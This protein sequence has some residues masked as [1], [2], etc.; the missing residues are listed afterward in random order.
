MDLNHYPRS[1]FH[2][3]DWEVVMIVANRIIPL[4]PPLVSDPERSLTR[5]V[6]GEEGGFM[7][8]EKSPQ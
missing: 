4:F 2:I 1:T 7:G 3:P 5:R 8:G 6:K